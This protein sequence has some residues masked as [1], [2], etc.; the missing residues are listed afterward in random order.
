[1]SNDDPDSGTIIAPID[2]VIQ[3]YAV[4]CGDDAKDAE[5]IQTAANGEGAMVSKFC[6]REG[7][8]GTIPSLPFIAMY[9][10]KTETN[11]YTG[12][13]SRPLVA[14]H[15]TYGKQRLDMKQFKRW[16]TRNMVNYVNNDETVVNGRGHTVAG[17]KTKM[18]ERD[19]PDLPV[20][21]LVSM[22]DTPSPLYKSL[23]YQFL[24]SARFVQTK[25][26]NNENHPDATSTL[27]IDGEQ[28]NGNLASRQ[29]IESWL[30]TKVEAPYMERIYDYRP[31]Q[32]ETN[33]KYGG[34]QVIKKLPPVGNFYHV[35][36]VVPSVD[37][38]K[39]KKIKG[40]NSAVDKQL[41]G[42]DKVSDEERDDGRI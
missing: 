7:I 32:P 10:N 27:T 8:R 6:E 14:F 22:K 26:E 28:F 41:P 3:C 40:D 21:K 4:V 19:V 12:E 42:W 2:P 29:E 24:G 16:V 20:V 34:A 38:N 36:A 25:M 17:S 30:Y 31:Y 37:L 9:T 18:D 23:A 15:G 5:W 33:Q 13:A 11:P 39:F 1:V 35:V